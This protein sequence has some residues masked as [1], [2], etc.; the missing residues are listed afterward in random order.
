MS[1]R[2]QHFLKINLVVLLLILALIA[3]VDREKL[4]SSLLF[5]PPATPPTP[6]AGLL[7]HSFQLLCC[8]PPIVCLFSYTLLSRKAS[9]NNSR[10]FLL[11]SGII[12]GLFAI[13][14]IFRIHIILLYFNI[15]KFLTISVYALAILIY[16]LAF[17]RRIRQTYYQ[18]LII[19]LALLT[20]AIAID[21]L[22]IKNQGFASL[23]EGIPKLL[24]AVNLAGYFWDVCFQEISAQIKSQ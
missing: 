5:Y 9:F 21:F 4:H 14:E 2:E 22:Q 1:S 3:G 13:N 20:L 16:G 7:T 15:P 17:W 6:L 11:V 10:H 18:I 12:T 8:L 23:S 24:S 19:A